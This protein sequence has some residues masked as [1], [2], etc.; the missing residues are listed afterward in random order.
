MTRT[1]TLGEAHHVR[2]R[3][4]PLRYHERGRGRPVV[5]V[6]GLFVNGDLWRHVVPPLADAGLRCI[7][8]DWPFGSH[9][10]PLAPQADLGPL[11]VA[12]LISDFL[13]E[14]DL[15]DVVLVANDTGGAFSQIA[16]VR[17]PER[18]GALVLTPSDSLHRFFPPM[19]RYLQAFSGLPGFPYL[20]AQSLRLTP[21]HRL[22]FVLGLLSKRRLPAAATRSYLTPMRRSP[23]VRRDLGKLLKGV[24]NRHTLAA[25]ERF[26]EVDVPVLLPWASEDRLFPIGLGEELA[27]RFPRARLE[28]IE[29]SY[30]FVPEDRPERLVELLKEFRVEERG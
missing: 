6:H 28:P 21:A 10:E 3:Q 12:R 16:A 22:P 29:D 17:H 4:G 23:G 8:P 20:I 24:D 14:L 5:F 1:A 11:G 18:L 19:F 25:A 26:S 13:D 2:L 7:T 30:T 15:H 9:E 27:R